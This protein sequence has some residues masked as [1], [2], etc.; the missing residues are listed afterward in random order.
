MTT[1]QKNKIIAISG[2]PEF[3]FIT[4]GVESTETGYI[5]SEDALTRMAAALEAAEASTAR[6][7]ELEAQIQQSADQLTTAQE[8]TQQLQG[9][10]T[11]AQEQNTTLQSRVE[12]LEADGG[13]TQTTK[14][15]DPAVGKVKIAAHED[16][17]NPLNEMAD[18]LMGAPKKVNP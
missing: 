5:V 14:G 13:I 1:E 15:A 12:E 17:K 3:S 11:T 18:K 10:L 4:E 8:Q 7:T 16:P 9:Q 6:I 2:Q